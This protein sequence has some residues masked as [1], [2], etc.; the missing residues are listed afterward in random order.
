[1]RR[2]P[3]AMRDTCPASDVTVAEQ[4]QS[5]DVTSPPRMPQ[6][7]ENVFQGQFQ[8]LIGV[9]VAAVMAR[10]STD[11]NTR[12]AWVTLSTRVLLL[13]RALVEGAP[14]PMSR[15]AAQVKRLGVIRA[16]YG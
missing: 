16:F 13:S 7:G 15:S 4:S 5:S 8:S 1:M 9:H 10:P 2:Q 3:L 11:A 14:E 6:V 12:L